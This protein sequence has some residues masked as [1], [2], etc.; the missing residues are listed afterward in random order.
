LTL[1][2]AGNFSFETNDFPSL[3]D[4]QITMAY[5]MVREHLLAALLDSPE[6]GILG[7]SLDGSIDAWSQGAEHFYGYKEQEIMGQPLSRL[8]PLHEWPGLKNVFSEVGEHGERHFETA[9]RLHKN[10]S[11]ILLRVKRLF[12]RDEQGAATGILE[13]GR[14]F[15]SYRGD[16]QVE[17]PLRLITAQMPGLHWTT[18]QNLRITSNWGKALASSKISPGA[19]VGRSIREFLQCIDR[20]STPIAEHYETLRGLPAHFEYTWKHR[21]WEMLLE[22]LRTASGEINGCLGLGIDVTER[23]KNEE[24]AFYQARHDALTG[25]A[26]YRE[27]MDRLEKEVQ[28]AERSHHPFTVLL[29]DLDGLKRINDL[30]GHVAGNRALQR[31]AAVMNEHCRSTDLAARYGGDEFAVVL[32]DSD[33]GMAE[34]VA[35]RIENGLRNGEGK[36]AISASIGIGIYPDDGRT[37]AELLEGADQQLYKYKRAENRRI[38]PVAGRILK[39]KRAGR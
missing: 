18:D 34:Q 27:F 6:D 39:S 31:L 17:E 30:H 24:Q 13:I 25:L 14:A 35:R 29:L 28:R 37:A 38:L 19:L 5:R 10:G 7:V 22:P 4:G 20:H 32:I 1:S 26:N 15:D 11:R 36:P 21:L 9:E 33:K 16:L 12:V 3:K 2:P 23:K 8:V